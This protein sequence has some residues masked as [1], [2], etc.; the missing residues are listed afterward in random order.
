MTQSPPYQPLTAPTY[1][2]TLDEQ[3]RALETDE[4]V[5]RFAESRRRL[6]SVDPY[7]PLFHFSSP[8]NY[9]NDPNGLCQWN[10]RYHMFYQFRPTGVGRVHWGHT[11]SD[12]LVRWSDMPPGA[13]PRHRT[14]LLQRPDSGR[15]GSRNRDLPR[16]AVRKRH[17]HRVR[18]ASDEL[19]KAPQQP[20]HSRH[21]PGRG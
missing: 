13:V 11:V 19:A 15:A 6:A 20:R 2:A 9:M 10:G 4:S 17:R 1:P 5:L 14:R 21:E 7:R 16:D 3:L 18:P 8:E 12:D